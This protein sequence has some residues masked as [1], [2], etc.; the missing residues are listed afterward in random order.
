MAARLWAFAGWYYQRNGDRI[1]PVSTQEIARLVAEGEL[2]PGDDVWKAWRIGEET[3]L[4]PSKAG[5][6]AGRADFAWTVPPERKTV[7]V[8]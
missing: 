3:T 2:D 6:A 1:G 4:L 8:S 5:V 7:A